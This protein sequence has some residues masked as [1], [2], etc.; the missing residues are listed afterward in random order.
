MWRADNDT[1]AAIVQ[2]TR[3]EGKWLGLKFVTTASF[4]GVD[5]KNAGSATYS[6]K[7]GV[8]N[9]GA[10]WNIENYVT[11]VLEREAFKA[12]MTKAE[13]ALAAMKPG[14]KT[15]EYFQE[16]ITAFSKVIA[17]AKSDAN[18]A[19]SQ[20]ALDAV[21]AQLLV[22][23]DTYVA[24]KHDHDYLNLTALKAEIDKA[25]K[26]LNA[27]VAGDCNGQ[28]PESA[29][30]ALTTALTTAKSVLGNEEATQT[31]VDAAVEALQTAE[32]TFAETKVVINYVDLNDA[33][34]NAQNVVKENVDF[35]GD[36]PGKYSVESYE[37]LKTAIS[38]A[39]AI[40]KSNTVN[41]K[42]VDQEVETL[43]DALNVFYNSFRA[44]DYSELKALV[45]QAAE[46]IR[47]AEAGEIACDEQDLQ[48]LKASYSTNA[49]ALDATDQNVIDK[50]VKLLRRDIDIFNT[51]TSGISVL[52]VG[53]AAKV[54]TMNGI[55]VG[56]A[57]NL[58]LTSGVYVVRYDFGSRIVIKKICVK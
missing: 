10:Y 48:D 12:A 37:A 36:G 16:D 14:Y 56:D 11:I 46:L 35:V 39:Q 27:S 26:T 29:I 3:L 30:T 19:Q 18:K 41:Q 28:Y 2:V 32:K 13:A 24:K 1:L 38:N 43:E 23:I 17:K 40:A 52:P 4:L 57:R 7:A 33:I 47:K 55:Y 8:G 42:R 31:E 9:T 21:T 20:E 49:A 54:Y 50:A 5:S 22:D 25:E 45:E 51:M 44:N 58:N 34:N 53:V 15:G 6:D